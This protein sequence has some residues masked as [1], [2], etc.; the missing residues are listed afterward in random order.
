MAVL[1][2]A[3]D[4]YC[5]E[6]D[7][8]LLSGTDAAGDAEGLSVINRRLGAKQ[9]SMAARA[10]DTN[11]YA[12]RARSAEDWLARQNGTSRSEAKRAIDTARRMAECPLASEA[13]ERGDLSMAEA[14]AVSAAAVLDP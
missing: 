13:F 3:V 5:A 11:A 10:A 6:A 12:A 2:A 7:P 4:A 9:A 1:M 8:A 14:D